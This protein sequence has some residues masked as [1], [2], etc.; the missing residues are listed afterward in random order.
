MR[1]KHVAVVFLG[2]GSLIQY[3][4]LLVLVL[5]LCVVLAMLELAL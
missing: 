1:K 3:N 4:I 2:L 5:F